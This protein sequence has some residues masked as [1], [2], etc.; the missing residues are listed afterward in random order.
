VN[1]VASSNNPSEYEVIVIGAGMGGLASAVWL[2]RHGYTPVVLEKAQEVGGTWRDNTYP[3]LYVDIPTGLYQM[4]FAPKHDWTHAYAPGPEI[5]EYLVRCFDELDVRKYVTFGVEVTSADWIDGRWELST[6]SGRTYT[7]DAVIAATGFLHRKLM[8]EIDGMDTFAGRAFHSSE[9]PADLDVTGKRVGII[10]TGSSGIQL[11]C[12]LGEMGCDVTQY[13][14]T[15]Q[16]I[17]TVTNPQASRLT[18]FLG[19]IHPKLGQRLT[20]RLM[21]GIEQDPRLKDP[22]WK[23]EQGPKREAAQQALRED[24]AAVIDPDLRAALTPD[25]PPGCKRIPKS[26]T[27][28]QVVQQPNVTIISRGVEQICADGV[29]APDGTFE[30]YDVLV[31]ATGFDTHAYCRPMKVTGVDGMSLDEMWADDVYAYRGLAIPNLPNFFILNGPY[32]PVNNV[33]IPRTLDDELGWIC[34]VLD[35][36][37]S[38]ACA[39][40]PSHELTE[41]YVGWIAAE[42][43]RTV[44]ADNCVN[45]YSVAPGRPPIIWPWYD[46][47]QTEMYDDVAL[48]RLDQVPCRLGT[49]SSEG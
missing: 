9:W 13:V 16:W 49:S 14:R 43:P 41:E 20:Q 40:A 37:R 36:G 7:A 25:Y 48:D 18:R 22:W 46:K 15:P 21:A 8:P 29:V 32:S 45:W 23:L 27:Y 44:W 26:P 35:A 17:E 31:Y 39:F 6:A 42:I 2:R 1:P 33:T 47:E 19:R 10:G 3:G 5:Q 24:I 30:P 4:S 11:V 34:A 28:Y 12:A 38:R